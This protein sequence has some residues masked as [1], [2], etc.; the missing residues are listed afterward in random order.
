MSIKRRLEWLERMNKL[1]TVGVV[2]YDVTGA[3]GT[4][5]KTLAGRTTTLTMSEYERD[6]QVV[7]AAGC[8]VIVDDIPRGRQL[9]GVI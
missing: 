7:L 6:M 5:I 9:R 3:P 2:L 4:V 1:A 8:A